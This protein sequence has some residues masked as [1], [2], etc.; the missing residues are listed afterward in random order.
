MNPSTGE[1]INLSDGTVTKPH[2]WTQF[3][4]GEEINV[5]GI[6]FKV[7]DVSDQRLVLKFVK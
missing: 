1:V 7:H 6:V 3:D 4:I 2:N 5:K